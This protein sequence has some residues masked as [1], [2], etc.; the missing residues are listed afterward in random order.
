MNNIKVVTYLRDNENINQNI[1]LTINALQEK[2]NSNLSIVIF[3]NDTRKN[4]DTHLLNIPYNIVKLSGTKYVRIKSLLNKE[5][6]KENEF[7]LSIDND[8]T[9]INDQ[10]LN[11]IEKCINGDI[12]IAWGRLK[13]SSDNSFIEKMIT[14]DKLLSHHIIRPFLW[15]FN[16]G[17][18]ISGQLFFIKTK[19]F[20]NKL[21]QIDTFLDDLVL[22]S[23][24]SLHQKELKILI[25]N[26]IIATEEP[27]TS[28]SDLYI[29]RKRWAKGFFSIISR[30]KNKKIKNLL[31]IHAFS[32]HFLWIIHWII[33]SLLA[34]I[35]I[36][37]SLLYFLF[38]S[39]II[40]YKD[41]KYYLLSLVYQI[42][43]PIFHIIWFFYV[44][45]GNKNEDNV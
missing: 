29:Q 3:I 14:I 35:N 21:L 9:V 41:K 30:T 11:F 27:K 22:G 45:K 4:I 19:S 39:F 32:Y 36:T 12:D 2:F 37:I 15:K 31:K 8:T 6:T 33:I 1:L 7:L 26:S 34:T 38:I 16:C 28:F 44:L 10:F 20:N 25:D 43:F 13:T 5:D 18:S 17:I 42:F 24:V 23:Y 40:T